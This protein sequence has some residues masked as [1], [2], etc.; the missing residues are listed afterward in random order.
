V[1]ESWVALQR[2]G[3]V[4]PTELKRELLQCSLATSADDRPRADPQFAARE[5]VGL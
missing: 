2:I 4:L 1:D 3:A 5:L